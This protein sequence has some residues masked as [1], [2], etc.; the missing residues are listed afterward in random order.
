M[1]KLLNTPWLQVL[2]ATVAS[3]Y[4]RFCFATTRWQNE[5][6]AAIEAIWAGK[7]PVI[8]MFWHERLNYGY[9]CWPLGVAQPMAVLSSTSKFGDVMER[10]S[11]SFHLHTV[12][13]S[14]AKKS[15]PGKDKRGAAAFRDLLRWLRDNKCA[16]T[17][18]DGPRGPARIMT[19]GSLKL[20]QMSGADIVCVGL[21]ATRYLQFNTWDH[22]RLPLPF[23]RAAMV[24]KVLS[25]VPADI[26]PAGFEAYRQM[27]QNALSEVTD[28]ADDILGM[29]RGVAGGFHVDWK[30]RHP[31][32]AETDDAA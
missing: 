17:T 1:K 22:M 3:L 7:R 24:W 10:I 8:L 18:P 4:L 27:A 9:A 28:R 11:K 6:R 23:A 32:V 14:S 26:D 21:S 20:S 2:I 15:N 16:V 25:P 12:R 13:G 19:E 5:N 30:D 29:P 31:D